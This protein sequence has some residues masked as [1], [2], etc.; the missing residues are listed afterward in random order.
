MISMGERH[1]DLH[2]SGLVNRFS[3]ILFYRYRLPL[4]QDEDSRMVML[5]KLLKTLEN[6]EVKHHLR[7]ENYSVDC[8]TLEQIFISMVKNEELKR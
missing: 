4:G 5:G 1:S 8:I 7:L 3:L 6:P 2:N